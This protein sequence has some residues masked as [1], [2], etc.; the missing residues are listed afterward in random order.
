VTIIREEAEQVLTTRRAIELRASPLPE[1]FDAETLRNIHAYLF[2][3]FARFRPTV[4]TPGQF[5]HNVYERYGDAQS[6]WVKL[7]QLESISEESFICYSPMDAGALSVLEKALGRAQPENL[8][9]LKPKEFAA[10]ISKLYA[11]LDYAHPFDDGNSRTLRTY[12]ALLSKAGGYDLNWDHFS[13]TPRMRDLLYVARD[14]AVGEISLE[15]IR[16][17]A[18]R[19]KVVFYMD[20]YAGNPGLTDLITS[21]SR[22]SRAAAFERLTLKEAVLSHPELAAAY[23]VLDKADRYFQSKMPNNA[24]AREEA[25]GLTRGYIQAALD[26]G[27]TEGFH[28]PGREPEKRP[29]RKGR[30]P[31]RER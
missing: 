18:N 15:N 17:P 5:R 2:Q 14:R 26:R 7:R 21:V 3:D 20:K 30:E 1:R 6:D 24:A 13:K 25:M 23:S 4:I 10:E 12:T 11:A 22:P 9:K 27:E 19:T 8:R 16:S 28:R 29:D 31:D